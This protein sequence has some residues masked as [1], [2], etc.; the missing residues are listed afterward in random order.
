MKSIQLILSV[1]LF[2]SVAVSAQAQKKGNKTVVYNADLHCNSCKEKIEKNI[3]FEKGVKDLKVD[4]ATNTVTV[5]FREDKNTVES[6]R[7]AIEK[8]DIH[9]IGVQGDGSDTH[10]HAHAHKAGS[11]CE[12]DSCCDKEHGHKAEKCCE[13]EGCTKE[14]A[15]CVAGVEACVEKK[16]ACG[17]ACCSEKK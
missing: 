15:C 9:V 10:A 8:L 4:M 7:T 5:T 11:M 3:P 6:I 12:K 17:K 2:L 13:K 14:K 16:E 1:V